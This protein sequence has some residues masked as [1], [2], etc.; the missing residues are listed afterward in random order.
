MKDCHHVPGRTTPNAPVACCSGYRRATSSR[1]IRKK[2]YRKESNSM[3]TNRRPF[4]VSAIL[5]VLSISLV[6]GSSF[7]LLS[8]TRTGNVSVSFG[9]VEISATASQPTLSTTQNSNLPQTAAS[10]AGNTITVTNFVPGDTVTFDISIENKST[11]DIY[12]RVVL[13]AGGD[14]AAMWNELEVKL[15]G[16]TCEGAN[17]ET[18]WATLNPGQNPEDLTVSITFPDDVQNSENEGKTCTFTWK[19]EAVQGNDK[20]ITVTPSET[21][22]ETPT[23]APT[24]APTEPETEPETEQQIVS[25][26][27]KGS[28]SCDIYWEDGAKKQEGNAHTWLKTNRADGIKVKE[29]ILFAGWAF[30]HNETTTAYGYV[31]DDGGINDAVWNADWVKTAGASL[32]A[33]VGVDNLTRYEISINW[34]DIEDGEHT[35]HLLIKTEEGSVVELSEW[36]TIKLNHTVVFTS[37]VKSNTNASSIAN[38]DLGKYFTWKQGTDAGSVTVNDTSSY[39]S[40]GAINQMFANVWGAYAFTADASVAGSSATF[41]R[42]VNRLQS[43]APYEET[44]KTYNLWYYEQPVAN[45][46]SNDLLG[47]TGISA[48][49]KDGKLSLLIKTCDSS[50]PKGIGYQR[51]DYEVSGTEWTLADDGQNTIYVLAGDQ[52][53]YTI[54]LSGEKTY[55]TLTLTTDEGDWSHVKFAATATITAKDGT[56][57]TV[58]NTLVATTPTQV[59]VATRAGASSQYRSIVVKAFS[60]VTIPTSNKD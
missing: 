39:Y 20:S 46:M 8:D 6:V 49:I 16:E 1:I 59:A 2:E 60:D 53:I 23:E 24:E 12:Y 25:I 57:T 30:L 34:S 52:L 17:K 56:T 44:T 37:N 33:N 50:Q 9:K 14:N 32:I 27:G 55:D 41:V 51:L 38:S 19:V 11:V 21:P 36:G 35:L 18:A 3:K 48:F 31:L 5:I 58:E 47:G 15:G 40:L 4:I 28:M 43:T 10:G 45:E 29:S 42:G 13:L 22:S 54:T 26:S 7:A